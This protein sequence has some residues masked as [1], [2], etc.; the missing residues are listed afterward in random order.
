MSGNIL[1]LHHVT[2][3][4]DEAQP[5]LDFTGHRALLLRL[6]SVDSKLDRSC[7]ASTLLC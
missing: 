5:D 3:T 6:C 4:V 7:T 2:A 1:G